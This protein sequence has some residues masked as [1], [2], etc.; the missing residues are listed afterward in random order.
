M[1][2]PRTVEIRELD[3][4][5]AAELPQDLATRAAGR[6]RRAGVGHDG[7]ACEHPVALRE[8]LEHGDALSADRQAIG[9]VLDVAACDDRPVGAF[10]RRAHLEMRERRVGIFARTPRRGDEID[11]AGALAQAPRPQASISAL[12]TIAV[13]SSHIL[14]AAIEPRSPVG[15][16]TRAPILRE[17]PGRIGA[18]DTVYHL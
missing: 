16:D 5:V 14:L 4:Q 13:R 18:A 12:A 10:E 1:R 6:R 17:E 15:F 3:F 11:V 7:D 8:R 9:G 2:P